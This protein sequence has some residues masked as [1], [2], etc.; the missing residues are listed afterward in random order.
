MKLVLLYG[1]PASGKLTIAQILA[2]RTGMLLVHNHMVVDFVE[3]LF[4]RGTP[5]YTQMIRKIRFALLEETAVSSNPGIIFTMVFVPSR[6]EIIDK[7]CDFVADLGGENCLVQI[8]CDKSVTLARVEDDSRKKWQ[9]IH[10]RELLLELFDQYEDPF[11]MVNGRSSLI[12]D[13]G[14]MSPETAVS[15]IID[16]YKLQEI[17]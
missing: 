5:G 16:Q 7:Y 13:S 9:K 8:T 12:L 14:T 11:Q 3:P 17:A 2:K 6:Q 15:K 1:P 4:A 10:S